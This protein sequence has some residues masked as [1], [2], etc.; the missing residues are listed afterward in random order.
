M[1]IAEPSSE[2]AEWLEEADAIP[3]FEIQSVGHSLEIIKDVG[4]A[5]EVMQKGLIYLG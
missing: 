4:N 3:G 5:E 2:L 1:S